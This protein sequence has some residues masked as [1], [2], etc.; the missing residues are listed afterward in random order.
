MRPRRRL[1]EAE[2][3]NLMTT[4]SALTALSQHPSW[5]DMV[6]V[7]ADKEQTIR[8]II[9]AQALRPTPLDQRQIDYLRG[10][11]H[12]MRW[13]LAVPDQAETTLERL[14]KEQGI[15]TEGSSR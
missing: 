15:S 14:F 13:F 1:S 12:G 6:Q 10:F 5:P 7:V 3:R 4:Q 11:V 8:R 2:A 9:V